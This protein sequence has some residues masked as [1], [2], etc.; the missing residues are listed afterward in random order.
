MNGNIKQLEVAREW[1]IEM[2][3][4]KNVKQPSDRLHETHKVVVRK[5][6]VILWG[7]RK[8][9][10]IISKLYFYNEMGMLEYNI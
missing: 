8:Q 5:A 3:S 6:N 9:I 2:D 10:A 1:Q 4:W 7:D